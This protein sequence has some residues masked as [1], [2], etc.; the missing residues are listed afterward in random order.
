MNEARLSKE[1]RPLEARRSSRLRISVNIV[2]GP[3]LQTG[4]HVICVCTPKQ[5]SAFSR[6]C[7]F[8]LAHQAFAN[9]CLN[10]ICESNPSP[11]NALF[12]PASLSQ[13]NAS[14][15]YARSIRHSS[16]HFHVDVGLCFPVTLSQIC[17]SKKSIK[18]LGRACASQA[19]TKSC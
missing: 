16:L 19:R 4:D 2:P 1:V 12:M 13:I 5:L 9:R 8:T 18:L 17:A 3:Q 11:Q 6:K 7:W 15:K 10:A 14:K